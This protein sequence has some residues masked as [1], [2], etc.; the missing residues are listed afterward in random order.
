MPIWLTEFGTTDGND[1]SFI[2][3]VLPWLDSQSFVE[4]YAYFMAEN[5]K[6]LSGTGLSAA[7]QKYGGS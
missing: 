5:G 4:R 7:G 2:S 3:T 1:E 6:L